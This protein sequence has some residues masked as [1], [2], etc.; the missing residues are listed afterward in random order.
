MGL[1][2]FRACRVYSLWGVSMVLCRYIYIYIHT[3][4]YIYIYIYTYIYI[5][6]YTHIYIY[7]YIY[8]YISL[9]L[10]VHRMKGPCC[11]LSWHKP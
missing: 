10:R 6:I 5:Y 4:I 7:I 8:M 9:L 1:R 2:K 11:N 3:H